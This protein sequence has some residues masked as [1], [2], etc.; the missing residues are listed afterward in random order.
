MLF[1]FVATPSFYSSIEPIGDGE[2]HWDYITNMDVFQIFIFPGRTSEM[3]NLDVVLC[4]VV[5]EGN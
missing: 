3:W 2:Q 5:M 1:C 4:L